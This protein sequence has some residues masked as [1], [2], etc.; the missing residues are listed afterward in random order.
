M[1]QTFHFIRI[2]LA[3]DIKLTKLCYGILHTSNPTLFFCFF[4]A[5]FDEAL[6]LILLS[7][8]EGRCAATL[9]WLDYVEKPLLIFPNDTVEHDL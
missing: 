4:F 1:V 6:I 2:D 5:F 9:S 3:S 7:P 8:Q